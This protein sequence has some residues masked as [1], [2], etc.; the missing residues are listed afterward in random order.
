MDVVP[1][2]GEGWPGV[3]RR[4]PPGGFPGKPGMAISMNGSTRND[5]PGRDFHGLPLSAVAIA[6]CH[7]TVILSAAMGCF[8]RRSMGSHLPVGPLREARPFVW[9]TGFAG[10]FLAP[11]GM[12]VIVRR[13]TQHDMGATGGLSDQAISGNHWGASRRSRMP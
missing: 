10:G 5:G 3:E 13:S 8:L 9:N 2:S 4:V 12:T 1:D 11:L 7:L 6:D